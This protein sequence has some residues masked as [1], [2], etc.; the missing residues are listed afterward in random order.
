MKVGCYVTVDDGGNYVTFHEL[1]VPI[2]RKTITKAQL[3]SVSIVSMVSVTLSFKARLK[4]H[5]GSCLMSYYTGTMPWGVSAGL[6]CYQ[7]GGLDR[8]KR[9]CI[10]G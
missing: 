6:L 2:T 4:P 3:D 10:F 8:L 5:R 7:R 9:H 1:N